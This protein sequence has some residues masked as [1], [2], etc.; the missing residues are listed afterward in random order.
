MINILP[1]ELKTNILYA[2][3]NTFTLK[4][5]IC[6]ALLM[7]LFIVTGGLISA[8]VKSLD[9]TAQTKLQQQD[10]EIAGYSDLEKNSKELTSRITLIKKIQ[11]RHYLTSKVLGLIAASIPSKAY[12]V[13]ESIDLRKSPQVTLTGFADSQKT[14]ADLRSTLE[15][16]G[17]AV[18]VNIID[19]TN[20]V[21]QYVP[22]RRSFSFVIMFDIKDH[23]PPKTPGSPD[24]SE[25]TR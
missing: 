20:A 19:T 15:K 12:F 25:A 2:K 21:D 24:A 9:A 7:V 1:P 5:I 6:A 18:D 4:V 14:V 16:S 17:N 11:A 3:R 23:L 22:G 8:M 13:T 10:Q